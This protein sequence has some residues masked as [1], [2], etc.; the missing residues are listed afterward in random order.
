MLLNLLT[1]SCMESHQYPDGIPPPMALASLRSH[2]KDPPNAWICRFPRCVLPAAPLVANIV[3]SNER[4]GGCARAGGSR[5][6]S[7]RWIG[8]SPICQSC[9]C[10]SAAQIPTSSCQ[11]VSQ[12]PTRTIHIPTFCDERPYS[13]RPRVI[14]CPLFLSRSRFFYYFPSPSPSFHPIP[15]FFFVGPRWLQPGCLFFLSSR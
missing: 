13:W 15:S 14:P 3:V 8:P 4:P 6:V 11:R 10:A 5:S 1:S 2:L 7:L 12:R 9:V